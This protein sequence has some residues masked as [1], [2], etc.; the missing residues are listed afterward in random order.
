M[1]AIEKK[2][3][4][5]HHTSYKYKFAPNY[6]RDKWFDDD[7]TISLMEGIKGEKS[8]ASCV[9]IYE[10]FWRRMRQTGGEP[11]DTPRLRKVRALCKMS[12]PPCVQLL[13]GV[14]MIT[15]S[16][17]NYSSTPM[18]PLSIPTRRF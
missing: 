13:I 8:L 1:F 17:N 4:F 9:V 11:V 14:H 18:P 12:R 3:L 5:H 10:T 6:V 16:Y 15:P 2:T 7:A